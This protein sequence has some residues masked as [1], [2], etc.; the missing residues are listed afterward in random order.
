MNVPDT[1]DKTTVL[2]GVTASIAAYKTPQLVRDL[3]C[4]GMDVQVIVTDGAKN[5]VTPMT[6]EVVSENQVLG[7]M[8]ET[9]M[10]HINVVKEASCLLVAPSTLNTISKF[11]GGIADNL[12]TTVFMSCDVPVLIAP[13]MNWR[14]YTNP[15]F[16]DKVDYLKAKGI[17]FIESES[18]HLA[19]GEEGVGRMAELD[20]IVAQVKRAAITQD[21]KGLRVVVTSGPTREYIDDVRFITNRSSGKMGMAL[22]MAAYS[23][24]AQ[25][26]L[27]SGP[28]NQKLPSFMDVV[29]VERARDMESAVYDK[30]RGAN[31]LVM[32][33]AVGDYAPVE[34]VSGKI[35]RLDTLELHLQKTNDIVANVS[36]VLGHLNIF[37]VG[38]SLESGNNINR[39]KEKLVRKGLDM[40][41]FNDLTVEGAG[42]ETDTNVVT[43]ITNNYE[44]A[45]PRLSKEDVAYEIYNKV[46]Q[47]EGFMNN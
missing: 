25:V 42:F 18:G 45:L 20:V 36:K 14:M 3:K 23:R 32:A 19:C 30:V 38:F 1:K 31:I 2:M 47:T 5:F 41:V 26:T 37:K 27:I 46:L 21:M 24:G 10:A 43:I 7:D 28:T 15:I 12:L 35:K 44:Y 22:A 17:V 33:A 11:A 9:P 4:A 29:S 16:K 39:A 8:F 6:L 13:A 40:I 34:S